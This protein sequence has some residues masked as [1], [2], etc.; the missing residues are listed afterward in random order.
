MALVANLVRQKRRTPERSRERGFGSREAR[1]RRRLL[2]EPADPT[3]LGTDELPNVRPQRVENGN[4]VVQGQQEVL[5][6]GEPVLRVMT[7]V[8]PPPLPAEECFLLDLLITR[9]H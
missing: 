7:V 8:E 4:F 2:A 1:G 6:G 3:S 5:L 9:K